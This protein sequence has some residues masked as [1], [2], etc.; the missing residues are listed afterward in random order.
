MIFHI[1]LGIFNSTGAENSYNFESELNEAFSE[2]DLGYMSD[3]DEETLEAANTAFYDW[4]ERVFD[5]PDVSIRMQAEQNLK[6][7]AKGGHSNSMANYAFLLLNSKHLAQSSNPKKDIYEGADFMLRAAYR[8][9]E[10]AQEYVAE[11]SERVQQIN[12]E[13]DINTDEIKK[14]G[15]IGTIKLTSKEE[16]KKWIKGGFSSRKD[17]PRSIQDSLKLFFLAVLHKLDDLPIHKWEAQ[18]IEEIKRL[19]SEKNQELSGRKVTDIHAYVLQTLRLKGA[20][21][22]PSYLHQSQS[23]LKGD[24]N[25]A[26][27][28]AC[29]KHAYFL[30]TSMRTLN[31]AADNTLLGEQERFVNTQSEAMAAGPVYNKLRTWRTI[32]NPPRI[33]SDATAFIVDSFYRGN[34]HL[35]SG[36]PLWLVELSH[37]EQPW[38]KIQKI[39][40]SEYDQNWPR[41]E[42]RQ[43]KGTPLDEE[44]IRRQL[45]KK[46]FNE[47]IKMYTSTP[48]ARH[49]IPYRL[50]LINL[51]NRM[52]KSV[53]ILDDQKLVKI[54][55]R[56]TS[57]ERLSH[58]A[59]DISQAHTLILR[60]GVSHKKSWIEGLLSKEHPIKIIQYS[61][62]ERYPNKQFSKFLNRFA[63]GEKI[64]IIKK[65]E[66]HFTATATEPVTETIHLSQPKKDKGKK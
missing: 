55:L 13:R 44:I 64:Q 61:L 49:S 51:I 50:F 1:L 33:L 45:L 38:Q 48:E 40:N 31:K 20:S 28:N 41:T 43:V 57:K 59:K 17:Y 21:E 65:K 19:S 53:Q 24:H 60:Y 52:I 22:Q 27:Y 4:E 11:R 34:V 47:E 12:I 16:I 6:K 62:D 9:I 2:L 5:S 42:A 39:V 23:Q 63:R 36:H 14:V 58:Y 35:F 37:M 8:R 7:A 15:L 54:D 10:E 46:S 26:F 56:Y 32:N 18:L 3:Y 66:P 25:Y 29:H 30:D